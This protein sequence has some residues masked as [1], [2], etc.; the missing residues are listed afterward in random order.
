MN[1]R[2]NV[3]LHTGY[4]DTSPHSPPP[5]KKILKQLA[6]VISHIQGSHLNKS[7]MFFPHTCYKSG[8]PLAALFYNSNSVQGRSQWPRGLRRRSGAVRLLGLRDRIPP[9]A[10]MSVCCECCQIEVFL[11][12]NQPDAPVSQ[13]YFIL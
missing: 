7:V 13:I 4:D 9:G 11:Q 8:H 6:N 1:T 5:K 2:G 3:E 10:W 12:E